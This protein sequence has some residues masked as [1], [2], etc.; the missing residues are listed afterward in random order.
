MNAILI[1][2]VLALGALV[3]LPEILRFLAVRQL[4]STLG[5]EASIGDIDFNPFTGWIHVTDLS[6]RSSTTAEPLVRVDRIDGNLRVLRLFTGRVVFQEATITRPELR[7]IRT[8]PAEFNVSD[9]ARPDASPE[10]GGPG[11][12]LGFER[13]TIAEGKLGLEDRV[14]QP[15]RQWVAD[16]ISLELQDVATRPVQA[17][18]QGRLA[19]S[20][21]G[22]TVTLT[23]Q[24]LS[25]AP[26]ETQS[27]LRIRDVPLAPFLPFAP[28]GA[29]RVAEGQLDATLTVRYGAERGLRA[30]LESAI[31]GLQVFRA[32][33]ERAFATIPELEITARDLVLGS[34]RVKAERVAVRAAP[35]IHDASV[36]PAQQ[37]DV[38]TLQVIFSDVTWPGPAMV[39]VNMT[40]AM[41]GGG[42]IA[43]D[44][45]IAVGPFRADLDATLTDVD[46]TRARPY[47]PPGTPMQ[48]LAGT[49]AATLRVEADAGGRLAVSGQGAVHE[50]EIGRPSQSAVFLRAPVVAFALEDAGRSADGELAARRVELAGDPVVVDAG[51]GP[52]HRPDLP[53]QR[54]DLKDV[55]IR[56]EDVRGEEPLRASA[57]GRWPG[58]GRLAGSGQVDPA[59][60]SLDARV[61]LNR[62]DLEPVRRYLP[63]D[64]P[65]AV[66][67]GRLTAAIQ[68]KGPVNDLRIDG[69]ALAE[70][71]TL[72]RPGAEPLL[73]A[74]G[75]MLSVAALRPAAL[76][77]QRLDV[78]G[79]AI[80]ARPDRDGGFVVQVPEIT[81][82]VKSLQ[83]GEGT[84][85]ARRIEVEAKAPTV[86]DRSVSPPREVSLE[87]LQM[88]V[89]DASWP[90]AEPATLRL[91]AALAR[92]GAVTVEGAVRVAAREAD[93]RVQAS[94]VP[95]EVSRHY[96]PIAA[97]VAGR[98]NADIQVRAAADN[99]PGV[100]V[101]GSA[102]LAGLEIGPRDD[103]P[104]AVGTVEL[105][106]LDVRWPDRIRVELVRIGSPRMRIERDADGGFPLRRV[107]AGDP[108]AG[109]PATP[110]RPAWPGSVASAEGEDNGHP[111]I[112]VARLEVADGQARFVDHSTAPFY[113]EEL[114][115][116]AA[117][118]E[119]LDTRSDAP[120]RIQ[121]QATLGAGAA[122]DVRGDL[123]LFGEE[124]LVDVAGDVRK[125]AVPRMNPYVQ[126]L[127]DWIALSGQLTTR[128]H[129]RITG[130]RLEATND[131]VVE[132][133]NVE[134][135]GTDST[136][137]R[138]LGVPLGLAVALLKN[139]RGEIHLS[140]PLRGRLDSPQ[141]SFGDT[142]RLALRN[143][144][145][146]AISAPLR[147]IGSVLHKG[148]RIEE[149]QIEPVRFAPGSSA[150]TAEIERQLQ[151]VAD[152]LRA[153][154]FVRLELEAFVSPS[155]VAS[156]ERHAVLERARQLAR[157]EELEDL[158]E[159]LRA[160]HRQRFPDAEVPEDTAQTIAALAKAEPEPDAQAEDLAARR[161]AAARKALVERAGIP[162][163]RLV[164]A[165]GARPT[166]APGPGRIEFALRPADEPAATPPSG[167]GP[168]G[169]ARRH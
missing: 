63:A 132:R 164:A 2:A 149:I 44:G 49:L 60:R 155:D 56:L 136:V 59:R 144:V 24:P 29:F 124:L 61:S 34:G 69:D 143:V 83:A 30:E 105:T 98:L 33:Q 10:P 81:A 70:Q 65:V 90:G 38:T 9:L 47:I 108:R 109:A 11:L 28:P 62:L 23:A 19:F 130:D 115:D 139:S 68:L 102:R 123:G 110:N 127:V 15:A 45:E 92:G 51:A 168:P 6:V 104:V 163:D 25:L 4:E 166:S 131:V 129:Y 22:G 99:R 157:E 91:E 152:F 71:L 118:I 148:D 146:K 64:V 78:L 39:G 153:S 141:W 86:I 35:T 145:V 43:G 84:V 114:S 7:I 140:V 82:R 95:L 119:D 55:W 50:L 88:A 111:A 125:F 121:L 1:V 27:V 87:Q 151:R 13:L 126:R 169:S 134:R 41:A 142:L 147:V 96:L 97:P 77:A 46:V 167:P 150:V 36:A 52:S 106:G 156:L 40:A 67:K 26:L 94:D 112:Q 128:V 3:A 53:P 161:I 159:V 162:S 76:T 107:L 122:I 37:F 79:R 58:H 89:D 54:F 103:P 133:L 14:L 18:G 101:E 32:G 73:T 8:G 93:L 75:L 31:A 16:E 116:V 80:E 158:A 165:G 74:G 113:S 12:F 100:A 5:R 138:R 85:D 117:I 154:P 120:A 137:E 17:Q 160:L 66:S 48:L 20:L 72:R 42:Q 21:A 57:A 135:A